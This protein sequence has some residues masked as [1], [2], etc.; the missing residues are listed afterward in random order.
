MISNVQYPERDALNIARAARPGI[1]WPTIALAVSVLGAYAATTYMAFTGAIAAPLAILINSVLVYAAYT[2]LHE[3]AH[4]NIDARPGKPGW[5]NRAVGV[6]VSAPMLHNFSLHQT[7]HLS[8]HRHLN[9]PARDADHWVQGKNAVDTLLR[10]STV[11]LSHYRMGWRINRDSAQGRR[12]LRRGLAENSIWICG[13]IALIA[14][15]YGMETLLFILLPTLFGQIILAFLFDWA[16]HYPFAGTHRFD[17]SNAHA[18]KSGLGQMLFNGISIGQSLHL[19]HHL[20]PWVPFYR[21]ARIF[22][23]NEAFLREN[24]ARIVDWRI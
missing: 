15:G 19:V 17:M 11:I 7:T 6:A 21:Y 1:A 12:A 3:A 13:M 2:P 9:D 8:H 16:V 23:A 14:T 5:M 22:R 18:P 4:G 20:Y 24:K 10:L